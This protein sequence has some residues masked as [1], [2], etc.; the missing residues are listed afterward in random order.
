M[1]TVRTFTVSLLI[2]IGCSLGVAGVAAAQTDGTT[3]GTTTT[4]TTTT[5]GDDDTHW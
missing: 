5:T 1:R 2:V 4:A 3:P